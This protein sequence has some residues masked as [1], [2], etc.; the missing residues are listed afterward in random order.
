LTKAL[1]VDWRGLYN[2]AIFLIDNGPIEFLESFHRLKTTRPPLEHKNL[3]AVESLSITQENPAANHFAL[4]LSSFDWI[5]FNNTIASYVAEYTTQKHGPMSVFMIAPFLLV[6]GSTTAAALLGNILITA[7]VPLVSYYTFRIHFSE[8]ISR[9]TATSLAIGPGLFIW[10]RHAAPVPYDVFTV[11]FVGIST[12]MFL[13][14]IN[15]NDR[16][17]YIAAGLALSLGA[18]TKLTALVMTLPFLLIVL[19]ETKDIR[20]AAGRLIEMGGAWFVVP[21]IFLIG[22]YNFVA[23]YAYTIY[24]FTLHKIQYPGGG[25]VSPSNP[26]AALEDPVIGLFGTLYNLRWL[27]IVCCTLAVVLAVIVLRNRTLLERSKYFMSVAFATA[28]LPFGVWVVFGAGTLS[29]HTVMLS[30]PLGFISCAA[31]TALTEL[32]PDVDR[33]QLV[34]FGQAALLVSGLQFAIN[35]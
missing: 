6:F 30:V 5:P 33:L 3:Y 24:K 14:G 29:R 32:S 27:N 13:Q 35:I 17:Y 12:Y 34:R 10:M 22:G 28:F 16:R 25:G 15:S 2:A 19:R 18:L 21:I 4:W 23:Q 26:A 1:D 7:V 31:L 9:V 11:L 20:T 8:L